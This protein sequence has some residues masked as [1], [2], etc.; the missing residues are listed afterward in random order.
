MRDS[1]KV[2]YRW[3]SFR[4]FNELE[5]NTNFHIIVSKN[6]RIVSFKLF[7]SLCFKIVIIIESKI[8]GTVWNVLGEKKHLKTKTIKNF[9]WRQKQKACFSSNKTNNQ[10][11]GRTKLNS[12][13]SDLNRASLN[14][15]PPTHRVSLPPLPP[16]HQ[17]QGFFAPPPHIQGFLAHTCLHLLASPGQIY[18]PSSPFFSYITVFYSA[19]LS[20]FIF[21][22]FPSLSVSPHGL[23]SP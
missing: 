3:A 7:F 19:P 13:Q 23:F 16:S 14:P 4:S 11:E 17:T 5:K 9:P 1:N 15:P 6:T 21:L 2:P 8:L 20:L 12:S 10:E 22:S 18:P